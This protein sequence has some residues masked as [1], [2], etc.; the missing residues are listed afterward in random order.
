LRLSLIVTLL[1]G[2]IVGIGTAN[3]AEETFTKPTRATALP[4]ARIGA[5]AAARARP[6]PIASLSG[7]GDATN[8]AIDADIG[9]EARPG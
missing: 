7:L 5:P 2:L 9:R 3:A 8:Y 1:V 4:G 6:W